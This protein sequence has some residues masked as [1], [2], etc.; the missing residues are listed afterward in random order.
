MSNPKANGKK[1]RRSNLALIL[2]S[3]LIAASLA[4]AVLT[5]D[6]VEFKCS[7]GNFQTHLIISNDAEL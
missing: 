2:A 1:A 5:H 6:R 4:V 7:F 3:I